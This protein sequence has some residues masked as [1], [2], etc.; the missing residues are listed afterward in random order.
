KA[1]TE[2]AAHTAHFVWR[3]DARAGL[4]RRFAPRNDG[5]G[6]SR[7]N[8]FQLSNSPTHVSQTRV[9]AP[10]FGPRASR[11]VC[12]LPKPY[13]RACG[14]SGAELPAAT[15]SCSWRHAHGHPSNKLRA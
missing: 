3:A 2:C 6:A 12:L 11:F 10:F 1:N 5:G 14:T 7:A 4:L 8:I 9:L 15:G 13:K